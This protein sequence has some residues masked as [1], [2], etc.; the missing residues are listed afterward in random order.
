MRTHLLS[1]RTLI[2]ELK[3]DPY[4]TRDKTIGSEYT[5]ESK[6][7]DPTR[8][9]KLSPTFKVFFGALTVEKPLVNRR[10]AM[11]QFFDDLLIV[12]EKLERWLKMDGCVA[13]ILGNKRLGTEIIPADTIVIEL[14]ESAGLKH[15]KSIR[16]KLK[17]NNSNSSVPWQDRIIEEE[18]ILFFRK[19]R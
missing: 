8:L 4:D 15:E 6:H 5:P 7:F 3:H 18:S 2:A 11:M 13:F 17:T 1:Y 19:T 9:M 16:H 14:F 10:D 12:G